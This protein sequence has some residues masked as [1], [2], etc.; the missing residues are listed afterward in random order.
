M[1]LWGWREGIV[2]NQTW[3]RLDQ[4]LTLLEALPEIELVHL[5]N[6]PASAGNL[7]PV[8]DGIGLWM[9]DAL[10]DENRPYH[11]SGYEDYYDFNSTAPRLAT[12]RE[13]FGEIR[14]A[15]IETGEKVQK[16][17]KKSEA[18]RTLY[19]AAL[20]NYLAHQYE[21]GCV[22]IGS[23]QYRGWR[24][25][26]ASYALLQAA[27][28]ALQPQSFVLR[29]DV[30]HDGHDEA[31]LSDGRNL[32]LTTP[33]GG[34]LLYWLDLSTGHQYVGN[35]RA[36]TKAPYESDAALPD[37]PLSVPAFWLPDEFRPQ[38]IMPEARL[39]AEAAPTRLG[40]YLPEWIWER[41]RGPFE[42]L[43]RDMQLA[44]EVHPLPAQRRGLV[45]YITLNGT[46]C[47]AGAWLD[48]SIDG[49]EVVFLRDLPNEVSLEKRYWLTDGDVHVSYYWCNRGDSEANVV[50]RVV[51]ELCPRYERLLDAGRKTMQFIEDEGAPGIL[52][53]SAKEEVRIIPDRMPDGVAYLEAMLAL[54]V[55]LDYEL[56]LGPGEEITVSLLLQRGK[57]KN[58]G[59]KR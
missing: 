27:Q 55:A 7:S 9:A 41:E 32:L 44:G 51:S 33:A 48:L 2:P 43:T 57:V 53:R 47:D 22:G 50:W 6:A 17:G 21:F 10:E 12:F 11:E 5:T 19:K 25:A 16:K 39:T 37:L 20:H 18:A 38:A 30:N 46:E 49:D 26:Q 36:V 15:L 29:Q 42:L 4:V 45:D 34:R 58:V 28:W 52:N 13:F 35:Q 8:A 56:T 31:A 54:E 3:H 59:K 40:K 24:G 14:T 23:D 1:G